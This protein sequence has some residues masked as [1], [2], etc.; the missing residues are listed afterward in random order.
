MVVRVTKKPGD[1]EM[2]LEMHRMG[3]GRS[4]KEDSPTLGQRQPVEAVPVR[5]NAASAV[6]NTKLHSIFIVF[7]SILSRKN[8]IEIKTRGSRWWGCRSHIGHGDVNACLP[9]P[10]DSR[11]YSWIHRPHSVTFINPLLSSQVTLPPKPVKYYFVAFAFLEEFDKSV[12]D[13]WYIAG[14]FNGR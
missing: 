8:I 12:W 4:L 10:S 7:S 3:D 14:F 1:V 13:F 2:P 5:A 9:W 11:M 6:I